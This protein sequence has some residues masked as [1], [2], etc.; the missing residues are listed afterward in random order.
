[1]TDRRRIPHTDMVEF[2]FTIQLYVAC[3]EGSRN[4]IWCCVT[5]RLL[6]L[7]HIR[8]YIKVSISNSDVI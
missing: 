8:P 7:D 1:M 2:M 5:Y 4:N 6:T 3:R